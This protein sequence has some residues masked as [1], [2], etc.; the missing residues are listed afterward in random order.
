MNQD[1][2]VE[3]I[4]TLEH[5]QHPANPNNKEHPTA[6]HRQLFQLLTRRISP[7]E[8]KVA[9]KSLEYCGPFNVPVVHFFV[10]GMQLPHCSIK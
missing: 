1:S 3:A 5:Y 10:P 2:R 9:D 6:Y 8:P 7:V 4:S